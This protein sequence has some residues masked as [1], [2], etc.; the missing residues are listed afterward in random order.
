M[1]I[2]VLICTVG[3]NAVREVML[4][5]M[6]MVFCPRTFHTKIWRRYMKMSLVWWRSI[7]LCRDVEDCCLW[8]LAVV[9]YR[10]NILVTC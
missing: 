6:W 8:P 3:I 2:F 4:D 1:I 7:L 9:W 10:P 5:V